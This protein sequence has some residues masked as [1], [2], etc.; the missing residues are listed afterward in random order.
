MALRAM[1]WDTNLVLY[2][3]SIVGQPFEWGRTDCATIVREALRSMYGKDM[4][5]IGTWTTKTGATRMLKKIGSY[6]DALAGAGAHEVPIRFRQR[7]DVAILPGG[8]CDG[9]PGL[10]VVVRAG[11]LTVDD[12]VMILPLESEATIMRFPNG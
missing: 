6:N 4:L 7:G 10:G 5:G 3:D 1:T 8:D 12:V 9:F 11:V 2:V